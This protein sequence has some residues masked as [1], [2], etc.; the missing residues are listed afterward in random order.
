VTNLADLNWVQV[1]RAAARRVLLVPLGSVEQHGPHLP[2]DT[3]TRIALAVA[4]AAAEAREDVAVAPPITF[5]ASGEHAGFPGTLSI[6]TPALTQLLVELGRDASRDWEAMLLVNAHGGNRDAVEA[7][8]ARL[9][10]ESRHC[11]AFHVT[12]AGGDAHAGRAETALLL[13]LDPRAVL[14]DA[15]EPGEVAPV[16]ELMDRLRRD[17]V[18]SVSANGVLGDPVGATAEEGARVLA[19]LVAGCTRALD[20]L[21]TAERAHA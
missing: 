10:A 4:G 15:R 1:D 18:R 13:H 20:A 19:K 2:L 3:D 11:A 21:F 6:G 7:A 5:G 12:P 9:R 17:G 14:L 16:S 8:L